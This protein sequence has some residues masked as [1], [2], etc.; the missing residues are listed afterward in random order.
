MKKYG[1]K[2]WF[3]NSGWTGGPYPVG[4]RMS[5]KITRGII[6][7]IHKNELDNVPYAKMPVFNFEYPTKCPGVDESVLNPENS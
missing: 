2:V 7:A 5:L 3:V 4:H 1:T 6:D